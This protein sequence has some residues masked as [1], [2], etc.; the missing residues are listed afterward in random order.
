MKNPECVC[1]CRTAGYRLSARM[2]L[3]SHARHPAAIR[4]SAR[5]VMLCTNRVKFSTARHVCAL[6]GGND[7]EKEAYQQ[8][9]RQVNYGHFVNDDN[10]LRNTPRTQHSVSH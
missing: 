3:I 4:H 5:R 6:S 9:S 1:V 8:K 2:R 7:T 10:T